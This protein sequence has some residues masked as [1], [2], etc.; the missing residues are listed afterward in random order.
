MQVPHNDQPSSRVEL[1]SQTDHKA[2][3]SRSQG[4]ALTCGCLNSPKGPPLRAAF[5][6]QR[7]EPCF[8]KER[9]NSSWQGILFRAVS[10]L[11]FPSS[12]LLVSPLFKNNWKKSKVKSEKALRRYE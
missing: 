11:F 2:L 9:M 8:P 6:T 7:A 3:S 10:E 4:R 1:K 12:L 5:D